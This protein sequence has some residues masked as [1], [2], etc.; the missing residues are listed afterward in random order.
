[1]AA[2][3]HW[4]FVVRDQYGFVIQNAKVNVYLPG[5]TTVFA[6]TAYDAAS[7]GSPVTNPF[8]TNAFGEVE[9]W[10]DTAQTVDV[11]VDDNTDLA[12]RAVGGVSDTL[13]FATFTEKDDI[14]ASASDTPL[15]KGD[16]TDLQPI[17]LTAETEVVGAS[18]QWSDAAHIHGHAAIAADPHGSGSHSQTLSVNPHGASDHSDITRSL[19]LPAA[20]GTPQVGALASLGTYPN[21]L[22]V[23]TLA[24]AVSTN[25]MFWHFTTPDDWS[26]VLSVQPIWVPGSTDG[27]AHTV[28]WQFDAKELTA[29]TDVTAAGT[30]TAWTGASATRTANQIVFD[31]A[32]AIGITPSGPN[33]PQRFAITRLG[34]D[35]AD[36]YVGVVNLAGLLITYTANQ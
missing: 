24:D 13:S 2:R 20:I 31:T 29:G 15:D 4:R 27:V 19:Y 16:A 35:G 12:Y 25:G 10:F 28:R 6:G 7:G 11:Q 3:R 32:T 22:R 5:T 9:A 18:N 8:T 34:A 23:T 36:T 26:S 14:Y 33:V 17:L 30:T 21:I 1:L